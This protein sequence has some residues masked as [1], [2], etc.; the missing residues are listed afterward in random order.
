MTEGGVRV[1]AGWYPDPLGLP[2]LRWWDNHAWTEYT[3]D[4]RQ[5]M[6]AETVTQQ[7][8]LTYAEPEDAVDDGATRRELRERERE[9]EAAP[10]SYLE[11]PAGQP[12]AAQHTYEPAV[13]SDGARAEIDQAKPAADS[14]LALEAPVREQI[15]EEEQAPAAKFAE[16]VT[17]NAPTTAAYQLDTRFDDLLGDTLTAQNMV[18]PTMVEEPPAPAPVAAAPAVETVSVTGSTSTAGAWIIATVPMIMLVVN[19]FLLLSDLAGEFEGLGLII[20]LGV[21]YLAGVLLSFLD[22]TKLRRKGY[23]GLAH[24]AWSFAGPFAYLVARWV[25]LQRTTGRGWGPLLTMVLLAAVNGLAISAVPGLVIV[26]DPPAFSQQVETSV[27]SS[28]AAF[29]ADIVVD[30]PSSPPTIVGQSF[31]CIA[32]TTDAAPVTW[33]IVV[34]LARSNLWFEWRVNDWGIYKLDTGV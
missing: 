2:Q 15:V 25:G 24:W 19:M 20:M 27:Q 16:F 17:E 4:A 32:Q 9:A 13:D 26:L 30:C 5:P 12:A 14:L 21:P 34:S 28:A 8:R 29:G 23:V 10:T 1:P 7:A 11:S 6:V 22:W 3:S 33:G 31:T 18:I